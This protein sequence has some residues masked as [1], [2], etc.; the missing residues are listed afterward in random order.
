MFGDEEM[1]ISDELNFFYLK[2]K[3]PQ[4]SFI[5]HKMFKLK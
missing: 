3:N 1:D 4:I 2:H 5:K